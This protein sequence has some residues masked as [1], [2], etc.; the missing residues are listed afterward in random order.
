LTIA[1]AF[2][3]A[4][5]P[6][7]DLS[8]PGLDTKGVPLIVAGDFPDRVLAAAVKN[9]GGIVG[10]DLLSR[11]PFTLDPQSSRYV[12]GRPDLF[13]FDVGE[14]LD[15][16]VTLLGG[17]R[18]CFTEQRCADFGA[19]RLVMPLEIEG[20]TTYALVDTGS[21]YTSVLPSLLDRLPE[22]SDRP[23]LTMQ[24]D[25]QRTFTRL[26]EVRVGAAVRENLPIIVGHHLETPLARLHVD[27]GVRIEVLLGH[28][29]LLYYASA[30]DYREPSF[31]LYP[32]LH[33]DHVSTE[34]FVGIGFRLVEDVACW[35][36]ERMVLGKADLADISIGD[37]VVSIDD[38]H[39]GETTFTQVQQHLRD[40]TPG[41]QV[42]IDVKRE[43]NMASMTVVVE[44][45]LPK[46]V[47]A[48]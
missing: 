30:F 5:R 35:R 43:G 22:R 34:S 23:T 20:V 17:G 11:Q 18:T 3:W 14:A 15:V 21:T 39:A 19:T 45:L 8:I 7:A 42:S 9:L 48:L 24:A 6:L 41:A 40:L 25:V 1:K 10:V 46:M 32:Y 33:A 12:V 27:T 47:L 37:C 13:L 2:G 16:P 36:V 38:L 44:D 26:A 28:S 4:I 31:K 29:F